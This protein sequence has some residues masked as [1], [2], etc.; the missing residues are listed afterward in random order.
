MYPAFHPELIERF[1]DAYNNLDQ[2]VKEHPEL[3]NQFS[4]IERAGKVIIP[5]LKVLMVWKGPDYES[6]AL[7]PDLLPSGNASNCSLEFKKDESYLIYAYKT[8]LGHTTNMCLRSSLKKNSEMEM[9]ILDAVA[10]VTPL[11][12]AIERVLAHYQKA[13][14]KLTRKLAVEGI[15]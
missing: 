9:I 14:D 15:G 4:R 13:K 7:L 12:H 1:P 6:M 2:I 5:K 3:L 11:E 8:K 10:G